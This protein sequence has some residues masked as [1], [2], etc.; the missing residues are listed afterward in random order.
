MRDNPTECSALGLEN[1]SQFAIVA[2]DRQWLVTWI[3]N[4]VRLCACVFDV[5]L[6]HRRQ[7]KRVFIFKTTTGSATRLSTLK[8]KIIIKKNKKD[9]KRRKEKNAHQNKLKYFPGFIVVI[10]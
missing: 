6:G 9:K 5:L 10:L 1:R 7:Q 8:K 3:I 2:V 4:D